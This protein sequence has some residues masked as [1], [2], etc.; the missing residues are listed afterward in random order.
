LTRGA[1][2]RV[3]RGCVGRRGIN[4]RKEKEFVTHK[5]LYQ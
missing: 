3:S 2:G 4:K 5:K 1:C